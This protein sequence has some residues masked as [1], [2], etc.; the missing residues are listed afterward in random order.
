MAPVVKEFINKMAERKRRRKQEFIQIFI[1]LAS[2]IKLNQVVLDHR[3]GE[4]EPFLG[5]TELGFQKQRW[6]GKSIISKEKN[7]E[8]KHKDPVVHKDF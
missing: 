3:D 5:T 8:Q 6:T 1:W 2:K 7:S 4:M